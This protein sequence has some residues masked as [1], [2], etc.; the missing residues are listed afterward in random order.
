M[1]KSRALK[2]VAMDEVTPKNK[3]H[4]DTL[5]EIYQSGKEDM[6]DGQKQVLRGKIKIAGV[7][8]LKKTEREV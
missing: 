3:S 7:K 2:Q 1:P 4:K 8:A 5:K 6:E